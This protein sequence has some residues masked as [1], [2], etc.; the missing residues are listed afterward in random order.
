MASRKSILRILLAGTMVPLYATSALAALDEVVVTAQKREQSLQ[1]A[2]LSI[3]AFS[4]EDITARGITEVG[5][6]SSYTPNLILAK[7]PGS[8]GTSVIS[9]IRGAST[10]DIIITQD[11]S[12]SIYLDGAFIGKGIGGVFDLVDLERIEV[13]RGPQGTLYGRNNTGGAINLVS[14]KPSGELG[15]F[16]TGTVGN[17]NLHGVRGTLDTPAIG[18]ANTGIGTLALKLTGMWRERDGL[19]EN[20]GTGGDFNDL[21]RWAGRAQVLWE[22][23]DN[24]SID[25]SFDKTKIREGQSA[26][27]MTGASPGMLGFLSPFSGAGA[28]LSET[29]L[30]EI[31]ANFV[32]TTATGLPFQDD[33]HAHS[34]VEGHT[35]TITFGFDGVPVLGDIE[36]K[37]ITAHREVNVDNSIELDGTP[38]DLANF[39]LDYDLEI[40]SEELQL[41]G[42]TAEG[43]VNYTLGGYYFEEDGEETAIQQLYAGGTVNDS[44]LGIKNEGWAIFGQVDW[45]PPILDEKLTITVGAR[46]SV[47][48]REATKRNLTTSA[49]S[50]TNLETLTAFLSGDPNIAIADLFTPSPHYVCDAG[51]GSGIPSGPFAGASCIFAD[52]ADFSGGFD[53]FPFGVM[54]S[55]FEVNAPGV[56][57]PTAVDCT[58]L[59]GSC[60][61]ISGFTNTVSLDDAGIDDPFVSTNVTLAYDWTDSFNTYLKWSTG[62]KSPG[63]NGRAPVATIFAIPYEREEVEAWE[64]GFKSQLWDDR[65]RLNVAAFKS[66]FKDRQLSIFIPAAVGSIILNAEDNEMQGIEIDAV[67]QPID[68][69]TLNFGYGFLDV[70]T[71]RDQGTVEM[72]LSSL[73]LASVGGDAGGIIPHAP[74]HSVTA[75]I[76]YDWQLSK[77]VLSSRVD[78]SH[79]TETFL[80]PGDNAPFLADQG[81]TL[82]D[83][84]VAL[85]DIAMGNSD[86]TLELALWGRNIFDEEYRAMAID[87]SSSVTGFGFTGNNY[88]DPRTFGFDATLRF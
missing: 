20:L 39:T 2:P 29:R 85:K 5:D 72:L 11:Q 33:L 31:T 59:M 12:V 40:F 32:P 49:V 46:Y 79:Q 87:F 45:T 88:G 60:F 78:I 68:G 55:P 50:P 47:D 74:E 1:D 81:R 44:F 42:E 18:T 15:G 8:S 58:D 16:L 23:R 54:F 9:S 27:Q 37:S 25:Y 43:R 76:Q 14:K 69:L 48:E 26:F 53:A 80:S 4:A 52:P 30:D 51:P 3:S 62:Y 10:N 57:S 82:V 13:L 34:D 83:A 35:G 36:I 71:E 75:G 6:I 56:I 61:A 70:E 84:R 73:G 64:I 17:E 28:F 77:A 7:Q 67:A 21:D 38:L 65:I 63:L 41:T 22:V 66:D 86:T 24:F 19:F